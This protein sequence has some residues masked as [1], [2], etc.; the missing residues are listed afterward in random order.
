MRSQVNS[1]G[2]H[3]RAVYEM[4]STDSRDV[5]ALDYDDADITLRSSDQ[6]DYNV[7][8]VILSTS[9]P[10]FKSMF[11]LPQPTA[12]FSRPEKHH[13]IVDIPENSTT[14]NSLLT[15]IYPVVSEAPEFDSLDDIL[16]ALAAAKKYEMAAASQ[17]LEQQFAKSKFIKRDP[18][19]AFC[20]AY[21]RKLGDAARIAAKAS[22]KYPMN[23][24]K[25][26][27]KL[28]NV[29]GVAFYLLYRFHR[30]CSATAA[31]AVSGRCLTWISKSDHAWWDLANRRCASE[32]A[33]YNYLLASPSVLTSSSLKSNWVASAPDHSFITCAQNVLLEHPSREAVTKY[34]FLEPFYKENV[35]DSC[36]LTL[37]GLPK[38]SRLLGHEIERRVSMVRHN[39]IFHQHI[40]Q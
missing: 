6:V 7:H 33:T 27:E 5:P 24:D 35:C 22:L 23:L 40:I 18:V 4:S 11:S 10:F 1:A 13:P 21:S 25:I 2:D 14:V 37:R 34:H 16:D 26:A 38:F 9:S 8:K 36:Q 12:S 17:R 29:D 31:Q 15:F 19:V 20:A 28:Q 39:I 30:A 3:G 32:C